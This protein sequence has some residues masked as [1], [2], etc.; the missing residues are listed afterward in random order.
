MCRFTEMLQ[1]AVNGMPIVEDMNA[2]VAAEVERIDALQ[3]ELERK[4]QHLVKNNVQRIPLPT[5]VVLAW[6]DD[7]PHGKWIR[8]TEYCRDEYES[9]QCAN[10]KIF[11]RYK[12]VSYS[13]KHHN[14][15][16]KER[17]VGDKHCPYKKCPSCG[18]K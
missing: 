6:K 14:D 1:T 12:E 4:K 13:R 3:L 10:C 16:W 17:Y 15:T 8:E 5:G 18:S 11:F 2:E 7:L 9:Q